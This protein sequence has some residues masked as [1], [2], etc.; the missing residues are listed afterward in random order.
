MICC[1][2]KIHVTNSNADE[3]NVIAARSSFNTIVLLMQYKYDDVQCIGLSQQYTNTAG[4][5]QEVKQVK[6]RSGVPKKILLTS[7]ICNV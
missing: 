7:S 4:R 5:R 3:H 2:G 1:Q 6:A